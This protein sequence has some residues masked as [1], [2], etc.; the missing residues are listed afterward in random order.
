M[1]KVIKKLIFP[2]ENVERIKKKSSSYTRIRLEFRKNQARIYKLHFFLDLFH[3]F[4]RKN[5]I[6]DHFYHYERYTR[7]GW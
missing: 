2:I 7:I 4:D 6:F 1:V 3:V 5:T